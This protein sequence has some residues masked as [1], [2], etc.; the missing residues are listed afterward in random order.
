MKTM[1]IAGGAV[2]VVCALGALAGG[3]SAAL[4]ELG[5]CTEVAGVQEGKKIV[6]HGAYRNKNCTAAS[7]T[8]TGKYEF[9]PGPGTNNKFY[10][11]A[12][13]PEPVLE[14]TTGAKVSCGEMIFKG[15]YTGPKTE[16]VSVSF[17]GCETTAANGAHQVCQ[18]DPAKEG[19]IEGLQALEGELGIIQAGA[20]PSVGW[21]LKHAGTL[22]AYEC[23]V[24]PEVPSAQ[25][26]EGSVIGV[27]SHGF[28]GTDLNKMSLHSVIKY[29]AKVG[30]QL[31][32]AFEGQ[33]KDVLSTTTL[34]GTSK[35]TAQT[36][37][38]TT[39]E[40]ESGLGESHESSANQEALE[41]KT[42]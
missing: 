24:L 23:G 4:P 13:E 37:L 8:Q 18:S 41:V 39:E 38:T 3:A 21:D 29:K 33:A 28:F 16:K 32:E 27:L 15:E 2:V 30:L 42:K 26:V 19:E 25:T 10:G 12:T 34:A 40:T 9:V 20:P 36:G 5:R 22:F 6:H 14:T 1:R 7:R 17:G 11:V 35:T 31:P